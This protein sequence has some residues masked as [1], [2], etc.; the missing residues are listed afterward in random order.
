M[1]A[2]RDVRLCFPA[3]DLHAEAEVAERIVGLY[4]PSGS[5]K[6]TLLD[7]VAG[8]KRPQAGRI[9]V[10]GRTLTDVE[11]GLEV[12]PR[13]RRVGYVPQG[14]ALFPHLS[15][16]RNLLYGA[17]ARKGSARVT[18]SR[19]IDTLEIGAL[20]ERGV[21]GLS[22]GER[23]RVAIGRALLS[24]PDILLLDEP[25]TGLDRDL[26]SRV[27]PFFRVLR[28]EFDLPIVYVTHHVDEVLALCDRVLL[29]REGRIEGI[30]APGAL[31]PSR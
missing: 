23:Q 31:V 15:V 8:L 4:G 10:G 7:V 29:M 14:D 11:R 6:T 2:L 20:L 22:G 12:A 27:L 9:V 21:Q 24:E 19:V 17:R 3:F 5:G 28:E 18:P 25:L 16:R 26:K 30:V 1:L 13:H